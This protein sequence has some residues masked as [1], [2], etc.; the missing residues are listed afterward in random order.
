MKKTIYI[1]CANEI[2]PNELLYLTDI[3][4]ILPNESYEQNEDGDE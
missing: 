4:N 3:F 2:N 1:E